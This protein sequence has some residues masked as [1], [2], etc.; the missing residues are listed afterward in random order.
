MIIAGVP[1]VLLLGPTR[2]GKSTVSR[3][4][5][6]QLGMPSVSLDELRW[7]YYAEIGYDAALARQIRQQGGFLALVLYRQLFD[8][9]SVERVLAE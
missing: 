1:R 4:L 8:V 7:D 3:L 2:T 5:A 6:Q 9:Y